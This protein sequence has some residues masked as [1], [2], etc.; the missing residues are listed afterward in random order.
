MSILIS[1]RALDD[2]TIVAAGPLSPLSASLAADLD[3]VLESE[4]YFPREKALLSREGGRCTRDGTLLEF[5]PFNPR[6][7]RCPRC[8]EVYRGP[9]HDR[10]W[11]YW[12]QLWL[13]ERAVH[14]AVLSSLGAGDAY[15]IFAARVLDGYV[16]RYAGYPNTDN[17][18]GPTR[19]FFSTYLESIWLLQVCLAADLLSRRDPALSDR[20]RDRI[21]EPSRALIAQFDE[22]AS[23]R[24]VW[25][26][27]ALLASA[28]SLGDAAAAEEAVYR[29]S[30]IA[31]HLSNGLLPDGTW[32]EGE[33]YHLFAHRG[34][35]YGV[36][37]AELAG[38]ELPPALIARFEL[39]F[40]APFATALPDF[41]LPARRDSQYAISLRQ[42]RIAEHCELGLA[43][44]NDEI[45]MAALAR[46]YRDDIPREPAGRDR[47]S[48]DVERNGPATALTRADLSWRALLFARPELPAAG[49]PRLTSTLLKSQGIAVFRRD[50]GRAY[51]ALD[52]G[53]SGGGHGHP[54]RLNLLIADGQTRWLDDYGT[55]SYV[56]PSLHWYRSTLAHNAPLAEGESQRR[57][58]G[59]LL[60]YDERESAGWVV[61]AVDQIAAGVNASRALVV[62]PTYA[63]DCVSW[64]ADHETTI[65]LPLHAEL[66][67][68]SGCGTLAPAA[69][70]GRDGPEDGFR[71]LRDTAVQVATAGSPVVARATGDFDALTV[72][73]STSTSA[74]WWRAVAAGPPGTGDR[75][76]RIVR[77]RGLSGEH[78][79]VWSW[80]GNVVDVQWDDVIR[81]TL[82]DG[83]VHTH[84]SAAAGWTIDIASD[85]A[86]DVIELRGV[87]SP[88]TEPT[89]AADIAKRGGE[90]TLPSFGRPI[91][92]DLGER[93]YR[94]SEQNWH[95]AGEPS[96]TVVL[97]WQ[98]RSLDVVVD[99]PRSDRTFAPRDARNPYD[100]EPADINGDSVALFI[101]S[102]EGRA[103]WL[104]VPEADPPNVRVRRIEGWNLPQD[105]SARWERSSTGYRLFISLAADTP[106]Y[107]FD[108]IVNEMPRGRERRRGQLV[109]SGGAGEFVYLRG[110]R[111]EPERL[112]T[113]RISDD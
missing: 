23:N 59:E 77:A 78:R 90:A 9:L 74:E 98:R 14:G 102:R 63:V 94:R 67:V 80:R 50:E 105:I 10:F 33:N 41:T 39:G 58:H 46:M 22:G 88:R 72:F 113:L 86:R 54:D 106:P 104:L 11:I 24:Q 85:L 64:E 97:S 1:D 45:L 112:I 101:G 75:P 60:A 6:E 18:L 57:V 13:A 12:Y 95:E 61:A 103:A 31:A 8:G 100:N 53:H 51:V 109:L 84:H 56:D 66:D 93:H 48:A 36:T 42:W 17:V 30:G 43:R 15:G 91:Y 40:A 3:R 111:H 87:R 4:L 26:D 19:L 65:D 52:Y 37:M 96:A 82:A 28:R 47:S 7:H 25:N 62:M 27:V 38:L 92:F 32:Y 16:E 70:L 35:W 34:L 107:A 55:G 81:V 79:S 71:F 73:A 21:I 49:A 83:T 99:V 29:A 110:D 20:V 2:R 69:L 44:R 76:F 5:D 89:S 108:V 68:E